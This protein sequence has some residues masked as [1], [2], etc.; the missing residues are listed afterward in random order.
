M[1]KQIQ[2]LTSE[3]NHLK[4]NQN[5]V[6]TLQPKIIHYKKANRRP[7]R[8]VCTSQIT[9]TSKKWKHIITNSKKRSERLC[10][11]QERDKRGPKQCYT[12]NTK[13]YASINH[14]RKAIYC[15]KRYRND[16]LSNVINL[17]KK[18]FTYNEFKLLHK[19]LFF[20]P[21]PGKYTKS[22][23]AKYINDFIRIIKLKAH[24]KT[25]QPL[26]KKGVIQFITSSSEKSGS[27]KKHITL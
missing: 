14:I 7:H 2:S 20:C 15:T 17:S 13:H 12:A 25:T 21:T 10:T 27:L 18:T 23:Y 3:L 4:N 26:W 24:F 22:K 8:Q 9:T 11:K 19:D 16:P 1:E 6:T 5:N